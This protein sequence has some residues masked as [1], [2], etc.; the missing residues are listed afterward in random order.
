MKN[1]TK[2]TVPN[3]QASQ[4]VPNKSQGTIQ[5]V[6]NP[7]DELIAATRNSASAIWEGAKNIATKKGG[8]LRKDPIG[9]VINDGKAVINAINPINA[10]P[11]IAKRVDGILD[12]SN[13]GPAALL[14]MATDIAGV[15]PIGKGA[16]VANEVIDEGYD[17]FERKL[18]D[19]VA[20]E[21]KNNDFIK[22]FLDDMRQ[23]EK[24]MWDKLKQDFNASDKSQSAWD[25]VNKDFLEN[26][27]NGNMNL[28]QGNFLEKV[29]TSTNKLPLDKVV[30]NAFERGKTTPKEILDSQYEQFGGVD[31][32]IAKRQSN[33]LS[34]NVD[35]NTLLN[36]GIHPTIDS[37]NYAQEAMQNINR[38][39]DA[40]MMN[41]GDPRIKP[42]L[43]NNQI[44]KGT[45]AFESDGSA[46][47]VTGNGF[48]MGTPDKVVLIEDNLKDQMLRTGDRNLPVSSAIHEV[49][50]TTNRA[51]RDL[52]R[53]TYNDEEHEVIQRVKQLVV[54]GQREGVSPVYDMQSKDNFMSWL[55]QFDKKGL[56]RL[57]TPGAPSNTML[58]KHNLKK[59][60]VKYLIDKIVE[61]QSAK[62]EDVA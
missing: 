42:A 12:G 5:P 21:R 52:V 60:Q 45:M 18:K 29:P 55:Q 54:D 11:P 41:L 48:T 51:N 39:I 31:N 24:P 17:V 15:L 26:F 33:G 46:N 37:K 34:G 27:D 8:Q 13:G 57:F 50:H 4:K 20:L 35:K 19:A 22:G 56:N 16:K 23:K 38:P 2:G 10:I 28:K 30:S 61:N 44:N 47:A 7:M 9:T 6:P 40:M 3:T 1:F 25:K 43:N 53:G 36:L 32:F 14:G 58:Q 59:D 49:G 62:R